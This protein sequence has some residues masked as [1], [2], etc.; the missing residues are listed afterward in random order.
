MDALEVRHDALTGRTAI[1][2]TGREARPHQFHRADAAGIDGVV[3]CPFEPGHEAMT[4]PE[5]TRTGNGAPGEPGWRVRVFPNLYP[6]TDAHEVVVIS[7][8][9]HRSFAQLTDAEAVEVFAV[10]RDRVRALLTSGHATAVAILNHKREAGAS[11]PHPHA[12]VIA[13]R[14]VP[15]EIEASIRRVRDAGTDLVARDASAP[16]G[17]V[18]DTGCARAWCPWASTSPFLVRVADVAR[19]PRFDE[20]DSESIASV[21]VT[22]RAAL[23]SLRTALDDPPYNLVVHSAPPVTPGPFHWYVELTPR[24]GVI[25]GFEMATGLFVNTVD[26]EHATRALRAAWP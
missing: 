12:Q 10:L 17:L 9:H 11:L 14:F 23:A 15:S 4:P 19:G 5:I 21:A 2:A 24:L 18:V 25:A 6:I 7:P 22:T 13:T 1:V 8:H 26:P 16:A 3:D 20:A